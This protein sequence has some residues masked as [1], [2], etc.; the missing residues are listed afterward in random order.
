MT[1]QDAAIKKMWEIA[2]DESVAPRDRTGALSKVM[3]FYEGRATDALLGSKYFEIK[4]E[5]DEMYG[6]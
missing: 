2:D 4:A 5:K 1:G 3:E 6:K